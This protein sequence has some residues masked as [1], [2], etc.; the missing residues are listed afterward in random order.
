MLII[1]GVIYFGLGRVEDVSGWKEKNIK[2][3]HGVAGF[4][5]L[6]LG[7]AMLLGWV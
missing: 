1:T 6:M 7:L 2:Y 5:M 4:I 3:L